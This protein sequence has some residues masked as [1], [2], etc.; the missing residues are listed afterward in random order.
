MLRGGI[1]NMNNRI[2]FFLDECIALGGAT[3]T[4]LRQAILAYK[5]G[6]EIYSC[7]ARAKELGKIF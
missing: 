2:M 4:L 5:A 7:R 6:Y 3:Q 1:V